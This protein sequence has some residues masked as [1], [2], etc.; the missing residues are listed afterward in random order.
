MRWSKKRAADAQPGIQPL[1][2]ESGHESAASLHRC[3]ICGALLGGDL[4]DEIDGE[5]RGR[6]ICGNCNRTKNDDAI[7]M[8][9]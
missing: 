9:W 8:G 2:S 5:G 4:E 6:D 1:A 3:C 7:T